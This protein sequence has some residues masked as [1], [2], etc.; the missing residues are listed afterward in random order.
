MPEKEISKEQLETLYTWVISKR[1]NLR[2]EHP[3]FPSN[4]NEKIYEVDGEPLIINTSFRQPFLG[5]AYRVFCSGKHAQELEEAGI[6]SFS[7]STQQDAENVIP[8]NV[9]IQL[10]TNS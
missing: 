9:G 7:E 2:G 5:D 6:V 3:N 1:G 10:G 8:T 4:W